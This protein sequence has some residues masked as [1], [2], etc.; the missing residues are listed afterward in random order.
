MTGRSARGLE[1]SKSIRQTILRIK[2]GRPKVVAKTRKISIA[3][4]AEEC[5]IS[6]ALIH[7]DHPELADQ[8]KAEAG[9]NVRAERN[10]KNG[11][12]KL[13]RQKSRNLR[14]QLA[15]AR[16]NH[17]KLISINAALTVEV[18][19]LKAIFQSKKRY[20]YEQ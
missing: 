5:G 6:R 17:L 11:D 2:K 1:T 3:A 16:Q 15:E 20:S 9:Q 10:K 18:R 19:E 7:K 8:I 4:V 12:L 13:E 14:V